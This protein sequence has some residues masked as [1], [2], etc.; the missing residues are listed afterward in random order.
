MTIAK[1]II[2]LFLVLVMLGSLATPVM[3]NPEARVK[4]VNVDLQVLENTETSTIL[5]VNGLLISL[6]TDEKM[7]K[8]VL[9]IKNLSTGETEKLEFKVKQKEGSYEVQFFS[10]GKPIGKFETKYNPLDRKETR[11]SLEKGSKENYVIQSTTYYWWD[12][13]RFIKGYWVRYPHPDYS[14]YGI[15]PWDD[16][17]IDG[18]RLIHY[19]IN[20]DYSSVLAQLAPVTIGAAIGAYAGNVPGAVIGAVFGLVLSGSTSY[21]L[22]DENGCIWFWQA[23]EWGVVWLPLPPYVQYMPKYFRIASYTLWDAL[24]MGNP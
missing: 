19:H 4:E 11:K 7:E 16:R 24:G 20:R 10:N 9:E 1:K 2:S 15:Q 6:N 21:I 14:Y 23:K 12:N 3:A 18:N 17:R 8:G 5:I 13:V 22:L